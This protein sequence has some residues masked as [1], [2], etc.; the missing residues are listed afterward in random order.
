MPT[1]STRRAVFRRSPAG[2]PSPCVFKTSYLHRL[3]Q[4]E[5]LTVSAWIRHQRMKRVRLDL[6]DPTQRAAPIH[7]V[8]ARWGFIDQAAFRRA[9]RR[10]FRHAYGLSSRDYRHQALRL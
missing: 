9:F 2:E 7:R 3:F 6:A 8:A 5:Q 4:E 1:Y 10:A